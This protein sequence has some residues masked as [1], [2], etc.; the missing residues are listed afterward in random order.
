MRPFITALFLVGL[1]LQSAGIH[2]QE[3]LRSLPPQLRDISDEVG[4]LSASE[5]RALA[6]MVADVQRESG[7]RIIIVIAETTAPENIE[8]YTKRLSLHWQAQRPPHSGEER[9]FLV[10]DVKD[11]AIRLAAGEK[12]ASLID[13][14][15]RSEFMNELLPMFKRNEY[16]RALANLIER[17]SAVI[18]Q[19]PMATRPSDSRLS[20][21]FNA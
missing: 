5:G 16:F 3:P 6:G 19:R 14:V 13:R 17:L 12:M 10:I 9:I 4:A 20:G 18:K 7:V 15:S 1:M 21:I 8:D 2:S 11:G